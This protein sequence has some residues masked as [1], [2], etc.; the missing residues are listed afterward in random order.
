M[1]MQPTISGGR[2]SED[3]RTSVALPQTLH[4]RDAAAL[5][6][7]NVVGVGIFTTPGIVAGMV[8]SVAGIFALWIVGGF[9]AFAGATAYAQ[10]A[11]IVPRAGGEYVYLRRAFGPLAGFLAGW[12]SLIAGF[13]GAIAACAVGFASYLGHYLPFANSTVALF[14]IPALHLEISGR[15]L[16]AAALILFFGLLHAS[17][18]ARG[19]LAQCTLAF[20][21]LLS[22]G[23]FIVAGFGFGHGSISHFQSPSAPF[24]LTDWLLALI[25]V[26]FT[27]SGWNAAVYVSEEMV[28][29]RRSVR[30]GLFVG[31]TVVVLL[32]LGLNAVF[33]YALPI[34]QLKAAVNVGD[35]TA[36][37]LFRVGAGFF[38][39]V[40]LAAL[41]GAT[42]AMTVA[43]P[44]V[45]FAMAR[46]GAFLPM[47]SRLSAKGQTPVLAIALQT[48][49]SIALVF[50]GRFE[51]ILI[52]TG[53]AIVLSS[54][55]A[56]VALFVMDARLK[57]RRAFGSRILACFFVLGSSTLVINAIYGAPKTS[58]VGLLV[59]CSG[60][61][62]YLFSRRRHAQLPLPSQAQSEAELETVV[63]D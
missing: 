24:R 29:V 40:L 6:I 3:R 39:P 5:I 23:C 8:P 42:S 37:A 49:W 4:T 52:Y 44:R 47:F 50:V 20:I 57:R 60:I 35:T 26:M 7:S 30:R 32:Y 46:D 10:L 54:V 2:N 17:G 21:L 58:A 22:L 27:Y 45:Y 51:E 11:E 56:G 16:I 62:V 19:K 28:D 53:F 33:L 18:V 43:G 9:L 14:S 1:L 15:S 13:S 36:Q 34:T 61:P 38:T 41:A 59:I 55:L 31:T 63:G 25:P 48:V 12:T